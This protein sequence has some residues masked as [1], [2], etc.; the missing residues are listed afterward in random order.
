MAGKCIGMLTRMVG[1][2]YRHNYARWLIKEFHGFGYLPGAVV[3]MMGGGGGLF[4]AQPPPH[5]AIIRLTVR[6]ERALGPPGADRGRK[7]WNF[8]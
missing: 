8:M 3:S 1:C 6:P 5:H 7:T 2:C 4:Y